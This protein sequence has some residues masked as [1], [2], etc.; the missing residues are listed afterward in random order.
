MAALGFLLVIA[1][2]LFLIA[3]FTKRQFGVLGLGLAAGSLISAHFSGTLTPFIAQ[4]GV[5][6][7]VP[8]LET[9]VAT[10][11]ILL[12]A[13]LLLISGPS[14]ENIWLRVIGSLAFTVLALAFVLAPLGD[15]LRFDTQSQ[16]IFNTIV[17]WQST[18]IVC[19]LGAAII[20]MLLTRIPKKR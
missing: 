11:L 1:L 4:Q 5:M 18:I 2:S 15:S 3:F 16:A 6:V 12:P 7:T 20:D 10:S 17:S 19:G 8:P 13:L 14:Y 9:I